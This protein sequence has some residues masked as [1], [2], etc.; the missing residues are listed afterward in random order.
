M[1]VGSD[2]N[3]VPCSPPK[4]AIERP[5][6]SA[7]PAAHRRIITEQDAT[8]YR[9]SDIP[10]S[11]APRTLGSL[12]A[13]VAWHFTAAA[14]LC[15]GC[16]DPGS[17]FDDFVS[18]SRT[19]TPDSGTGITDAGPCEVHAGDVSGRYLLAISVTLAPATPIVSLTDLST[20][21]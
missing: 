13:R 11:S 19:S 2:V 6:A 20:P 21:A 8:V 1:D 18:R 16:V 7:A 3:G 15:V 17:T 9:M 12:R 4:R 5:D 14:T 10:R